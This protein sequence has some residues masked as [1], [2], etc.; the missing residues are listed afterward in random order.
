MKPPFH[1]LFATASSVRNGGPYTALARGIFTLRGM[2]NTPADLVDPL[3]H[4]FRARSGRGCAVATAKQTVT[5]DRVVPP[6]LP[7]FPE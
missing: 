1:P 6:P 4:H 7:K 5:F 2:M 3:H